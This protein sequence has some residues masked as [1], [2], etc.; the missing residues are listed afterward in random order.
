MGSDYQ[1]QL[2]ELVGKENLEERYGGDLPNRESGLFP[3]NMDFKGKQNLIT[4][5]EAK[6]KL[7]ESSKTQL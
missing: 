4:P 2:H 3:P 1:S 7:L 5:R 6:E